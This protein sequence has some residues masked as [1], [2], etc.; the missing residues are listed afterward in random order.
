MSYLAWFLGLMLILSGAVQAASQELVLETSS[1]KLYGT[2]ET[3]NGNGPFTV[4]L[5][6][7]GSGPTDRDGNN[8]L[9]GRND[10]LKMLAEGLVQNGIASLRIDK[11]AI[12]KSAG[13]AVR[14]EDLRFETY[15]QDSVAWLELLR[16]DKRFSKFVLIGHS[17]GSLIGMIAAR[18]AKAD[19]FVSL[20]GVGQAAD[21]LLLEQ[22]KPQLSPEMYSETQRV[23][24]ELGA[25]RS[26]PE[27]Q[28]KLPAQLTAQLFRA[29][30][31]PYLISWFRY[32]PAQEIAKLSVPVLVVQGTT[33]LQVKPKEAD[34]LAAANPRAK[35]VMIE[36]MNHVL[37]TA[38]AD[39]AANFATY[40]NPNLPLA[41]GLLDN[42]VR[43]IK[44][45]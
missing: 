29:S 28:I 36:G 23:L 32:N 5:I 12:G 18:E 42:I 15:I 17:E 41:P 35:K 39:P 22:L 13:A 4:A 30:L 11:R 21:T 40:S 24:A 34:A 6:H 3:P 8:P 14:E 19:A 33:D 38:P 7:P 16:K 26:V 1:G 43:F 10:G 45:L 9:A 2:L 37:K 31:Q 44:A 25:G 27:N 20:A